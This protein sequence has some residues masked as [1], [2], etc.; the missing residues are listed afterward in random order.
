MQ[1]HNDNTIAC[2]QSP[3]RP[4]VPGRS[5]GGPSGQ[6]EIGGRKHEPM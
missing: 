4:E 3:G 1:Y 5:D 6:D 2:D